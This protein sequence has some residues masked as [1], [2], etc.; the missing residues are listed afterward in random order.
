LGN[1]QTVTILCADMV[2]ST[3]LSTVPD[4]EAAAATSG[5]G[6]AAP[7]T[8]LHGYPPPDSPKSSRCTRLR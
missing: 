2:G 8:V 5:S 1:T 3:E 6:L 4:P 7:V